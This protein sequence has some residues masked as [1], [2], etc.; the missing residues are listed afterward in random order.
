MVF[1]N[2]SRDMNITKDMD[3][4][5]HKNIKMDSELSDSVAIFTYQELLECRCRVNNEIA[6]NKLK[7]IFDQINKKNKPVVKTDMRHKLC[8]I[9][10]KLNTKNFK[11]LFLEIIQLKI[12][13]EQIN[14]MVTEIYMSA[15]SNHNF[16]Q[17]YVQLISEIVKHNKQ[18]TRRC[19]LFLETFLSQVKSTFE[20]QSLIE[21]Y[22]KSFP[23]L[24]NALYATNLVSYDLINCCLNELIRRNTDESITTATL[25]M[26]EQSN[27]LIPYEFWMYYSILKS[28]KNISNKTKYLIMDLYDKFHAFEQQVDTQPCCAQPCDTQPCDTQPYCVQPCDTQPCCAQPCDTQPYCAQPCCAQPCD[29]QPCDTQPCATQPCCAQPC[30]TQPCCAQPCDAQPCDAQ[31]CYFHNDSIDMSKYEK[32]AKSIVLEYNECF[33]TG[34]STKDTVDNIYYYFE[35]IDEKHYHIIIQ[36]I[37]LYLFENTRHQDIVHSLLACLNKHILSE[38][39]VQKGVRAIKGQL[40]DLEIDFPQCK[41]VFQSVQA[42]QII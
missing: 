34:I 31:P 11:V 36:C 18:D 20:D 1:L 40:D 12:S 15:L 42:A 39:V 25:M 10:N 24:M 14:L 2:T 30:D 35:D 37:I 6:T 5:T 28:L 38:C 41:K 4:N 3:T 16:T 17:L 7:C 8:C 23:K 33:S 21:K 19:N 27:N 26:M 13:N 29:T 9:L 32:R 22:K